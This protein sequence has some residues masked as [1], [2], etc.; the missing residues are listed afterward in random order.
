LS[1]ANSRA[2]QAGER[3]N[4]HSRDLAATVTRHRE[5]KPPPRSQRAGA[6]S[7]GAPRPM[8]PRVTTSTAGLLARGSL[9]CAAFPVAQWLN[10]A[11]LSAYSCW[12]S[13]GIRLTPSPRSLSIPEGNR[14]NDRLTW[15]LVRQPLLKSD[16]QSCSS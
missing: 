2:H 16:C 5:P 13:R 6:I 7:I 12:G 8:C 14:R 10:G 11:R 1:P 15:G 9:P 4:G 3:R